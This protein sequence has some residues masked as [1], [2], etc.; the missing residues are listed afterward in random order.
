MRLHAHRIATVH[1]AVALATA[2][3]VV[4]VR[5]VVLVIGRVCGSAPGMRWS[6][7]QHGVLRLRR[8]R[9]R[10]RSHGILV[11]AE[12][13]LLPAAQTRGLLVLLLLLLL[14]VTLLSEGGVVGVCLKLLLVMLL[15]LLLLLMCLL[16]LLNML[17]LLH[18]FLVAVHAGQQ[19]N[20]RSKGASRRDCRSGLRECHS[21]RSD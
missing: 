5:T 2:E 3:G 8:G 6:C 17:L 18:V 7:S 14:L 16:L 13:K 4:E 9:G 15:L 1:V 20:R 11:D 19:E 21:T 12:G 10:E